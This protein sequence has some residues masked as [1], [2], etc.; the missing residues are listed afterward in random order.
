MSSISSIGQGAYQ[1][2]QSISGNAPPV[3]NASSATG[4]QIDSTSNAA[5]TV[6]G[7]GG[8][9]HHHHNQSGAFSKIE[10]AVTGALQAAQS[11]G[12]SSDPNQVIED[13]ISKIFKNSSSANPQA[14]PGSAN[15]PGSDPDGDGSTNAAGQPDAG[16][17]AQQSFFQSLQSLGVSPQQFHSDFLAAIK[18]AQGGNVN[19]S[20]LFSSFPPGTTVDTTA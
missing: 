3:T 6:Q 13:A 11:A 16:N 20:A 15:P 14:S 9:H 19:P 1:F 7:S 8:G 2:L 5:Q 17:S 18:D 4:V 12:S 10:A